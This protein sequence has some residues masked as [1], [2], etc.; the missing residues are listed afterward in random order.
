MLT[1]LTCMHKFEERQ[2]LVFLMHAHF[3]VTAVVSNV[4]SNYF[5]A[6]QAHN[7]YQQND[8]I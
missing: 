6:K 4:L 8:N 3:A 7:N 2:T 5:S 1:N